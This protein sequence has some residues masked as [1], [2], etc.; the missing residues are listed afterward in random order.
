VGSK[1]SRTK[2]LHYGLDGEV[3]KLRAIRPDIIVHRIGADENTL[4]VETKRIENRKDAI[5]KAKLRA[6]TSP[7][8][9]YAYLVG[10]HL[11]IDMTRGAIETC[12]VFVADQTDSDLAA[13]LRGMLPSIGAG[14]V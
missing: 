4:V 3:T 12:E 10:V 6:M 5:D 11:V 2:K 1:T 13:A 14:A 8:G 9:G 7:E